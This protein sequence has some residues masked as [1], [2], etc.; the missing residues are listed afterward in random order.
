MIKFGIKEKRGTGLLLELSW[1]SKKIK[2]PNLM[3]DMSWKPG[4]E[5]FGHLTPIW[6]P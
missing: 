5:I 4:L 3:C 2:S 1:A 6:Q